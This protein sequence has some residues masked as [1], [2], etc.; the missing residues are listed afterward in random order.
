MIGIPSFLKMQLRWMCICLGLVGVL[1]VALSV[2]VF[3]A[4]DFTGTQMLEPVVEM[5]I[6]AYS[7][8]VIYVVGHGIIK[9][10]DI[11]VE[12]SNC[13]ALCVFTRND[14]LRETAD[15]LLFSIPAMSNPLPARSYAK[16]LFLGF[17]EEAPSYYPW[18][19]DENWMRGLNRTYG[20]PATKSDGH[21]WVPLGPFPFRSAYMESYA[22]RFDFDPFFTLPKANTRRTE[23]ISWFGS[24]CRDKSNRVDFVQKLS[25]LVPLHSY[26]ACM[27][28]T[29]EGPNQEGL[30]H[31][32]RDDNKVDLLQKYVFDLALENSRCGDY[33]TEK[34]WQSLAAGTIPVYLGTATVDKY[35]P[36]RDC[37]IRVSDFDSVSALAAYLLE[38]WDT[39]F[40]REK[41]MCRFDRVASFTHKEGYGA[42]LRRSWYHHKKTSLLC[43]FCEGV[44]EL[45]EKAAMGISV[46]APAYPECEPVSPMP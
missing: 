21:V 44:A 17:S 34:I 39:P 7:S 16:Q 6:H 26:G 35:I 32:Q 38:L 40:L 27:K 33:V 11:S 46:T 43:L 13:S 12:L 42:I 15:A 20:Y 23:M 9:L 22:L 28:N 45:K 4:E 30:S 8:P 41:H 2:S 19:S 10:P 31:Y 18:L 14:S 37:I 29:D 1:S 5:T 24:N 3:S 36:H 25:K